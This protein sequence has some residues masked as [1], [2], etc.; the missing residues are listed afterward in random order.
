MKLPLERNVRTRL[1]P[2]SA[3]LPYFFKCQHFPENSRAVSA[4][5]ELGAVLAPGCDFP[6][7]SALKVQIFLGRSEQ[8]PAGPIPGG[9]A[10]RPQAAGAPA[11]H[12]GAELGP[13]FTVIFIAVFITS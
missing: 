4:Q 10:S 9:R 2:C 8:D 1:L 11:A 5:P 6:A 7:E 13:K 3:Q 12:A